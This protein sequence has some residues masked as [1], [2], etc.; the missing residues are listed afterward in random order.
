MPR[1]LI[2]S[3]AERSRRA[4]GVESLRESVEASRVLLGQ[5]LAQQRSTLAPDDFAGAEFR[6]FSQFGEDGILQHLIRHSTPGPRTFVE[7]GVEDYSEANSR[8][9]LESDSWTGV[10]I[11]GNRRWLDRLRQRPLVW[12][13]GLAVVQAFLTRETI[14]DVLAAAGVGGDLGLLSIDV[15]GVDWFLW[16]ALKVASPRIVVCEY[17]ALFGPDA[18]ITIPYRA[19]FNA[20]T[21][22]PS[23]QYYGCSLAA[24]AVLG[25][26]KG[27]SLVASN[28][29]GNNAF[30]VRNDALGSLQQVQPEQVWRSP[31][32]RTSRGHRGLI[33]GLPP[34]RI[35]QA[36]GDLPV[37]DLVTGTEV[38]ICDAVGAVDFR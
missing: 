29:A 15:D 21:A 5:V 18:A 14:N 26:R 16:E 31:R 12:R 33:E 19:D 3:L 36:I 34:D 4:L 27:Y 35:L 10:V 37:V 6:V 20:W 25:R 13:N 7:F 38:A 11:E 32:F 8:F 17:N 9:L 23:A 22:H 1:H 30:L 2:D 24:V 28:A